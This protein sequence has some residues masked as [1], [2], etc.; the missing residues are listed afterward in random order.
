MVNYTS[1]IRKFEGG[2]DKK[3]V[4][5]LSDMVGFFK[6]N[7]GVRAILKKKRSYSLYCIY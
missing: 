2:Y 7:K 6:D 4:R 5:K 1:T 3:A